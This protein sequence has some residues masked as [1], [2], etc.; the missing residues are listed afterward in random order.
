MSRSAK[1]KSKVVLNYY[2][3]NYGNFQTELYAEI[4]REAFGQ[5]IGQNSWLTAEEQD[6]FL[7]WLDLSAGRMLLD[8]ACGSGGPTLR[9]VETT[10]CSVVGIDLHEQAINTAKS[11]ATQRNLHEFAEFRVDTLG[12]HGIDRVTSAARGN[13]KALRA[14]PQAVHRFA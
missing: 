12:A 1:S 8:V 4:R 10:G 3:A 14:C 13:C 2:D 5:D 6:M 7:G 9:M 11:L